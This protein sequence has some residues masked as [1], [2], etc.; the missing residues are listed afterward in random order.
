[1]PVGILVPAVPQLARGPDAYAGGSSRASRASEW[2]VDPGVRVR[3]GW[4]L[5]GEVPAPQQPRGRRDSRYED[6]QQHRQ[7]ADWDGAADQRVRWRVVV[8]GLRKRRKATVDHAW[9]TKLTAKPTAPSAMVAPTTWPR[10]RPAAETAST[11]PA[12]HN[13]SPRPSTPSCG[14]P[15]K[16][17][18]LMQPR[19]CRHPDGYRGGRGHGDQDRAGDQGGGPLGQEPG[20]GDR[21][22]HEQLD[23]AG[24]D[25]GGDRR[26]PEGPTTVSCIAIQ[27]GC[28]RPAPTRPG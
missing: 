17:H 1:M 12:I 5:W 22:D 9:A 4:P 23:G 14:H 8:E 24:L 27:N 26:G 3:Q 21:P 2:G 19:R 16:R 10:W 13:A 11:G 28:T 18:R 20:A 6:G 25:V 15:R 7:G